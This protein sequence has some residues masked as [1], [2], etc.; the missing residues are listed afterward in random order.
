[1]DI[2]IDFDGTVVKHKFPMI[3]DDIGA[4]PFLKKLVESNHNLILF[5][6]R[7][8]EYLKDAISWF[9]KNEIPLYGIQSNPR[10]TWT[11]SPKAWGD[12][13]ID[14]IA[15]GCPLT[16]DIEGNIFVDWVEV[17]KMLKHIIKS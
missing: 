17:E 6:M 3:G 4:V 9:E 1:M 16:S 12:L 2:I 8:D 14:D 10:Q 11:T 7:Y 15:L 5:T 13:I